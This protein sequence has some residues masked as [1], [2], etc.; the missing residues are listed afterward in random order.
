M[1]SAR[2][3]LAL[4]GPGA[5]PREGGILVL[6]PQDPAGLEPLPR[7]RSCVV[8]GF[9]PLHD[10]LAAAGWQV[11]PELPPIGAVRAGDL[12]AAVIFLPRSRAAARAL[13]AAA[14][15]RLPAGAPVWIDGQKSDGID[16][17]LRELRARATVSEALSKAHGKIFRL[18]LLAAD[19]FAD[20]AAAWMKPAP[21]F[22]TLPG[23][24]SAEKVDRGSAL[25]AAAL[26]A[27]SG[28][29][30]DL[31][32]GWGWLS[33]QMLGHSGVTELHLVEADHAALEAARA[34]LR[35]PRARFHWA[36]A[37]R[38]HAAGR[39]DAIVMNPP[40]HVARAAEPDLGQGFIRAAARLLSP[41]GRLF[42]VANRHLPY[43]AVLAEAF[44][45]Q[46]EIGGDGSFKLFAARH[47]RGPG[48]AR[49]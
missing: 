22:V 35:D 15:T 43:E 9:R 16:A 8:Q 23:V 10:A 46:G 1:T 12:A 31:G 34:N 32:A 48:R 6:G 13:V 49:R 17:M 21:G 33:A 11:L 7:D 14:A 44:R 19:A 37:T 4:A 41:A 2:L 5:L 39:F 40:F 36:D 42:M 25:L 26:P 18:D 28:R 45:E 27:L 24:F 20:W 38:F 3:S 29:V 47:P 30:A